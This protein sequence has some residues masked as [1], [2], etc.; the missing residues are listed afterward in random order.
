MPRVVLGGDVKLRK[1]EG[2]ELRSLRGLPQCEI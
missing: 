2:E 1:V